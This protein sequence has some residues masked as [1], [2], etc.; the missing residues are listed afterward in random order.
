MA[1]P[2]FAFG[3]K[4]RR[5]ASLSL[6]ESPAL[7]GAEGATAPETLRHTDQAIDEKTLESGAQAPADGITFSGKKTEGAP[8]N[9]GATALPRRCDRVFAAPTQ[10]QPGIQAHSA[11]CAACRARRALRA[12]RGLRD[13]D[14]V[15]ERHSQGAPAHPGRGRAVRCLAYGPAR[16]S[17]ACRRNGG[18]SARTRRSDADRCARPGRRPTALRAAHQ[19]DGRHRRRSDDRKASRPLRP[20]RQCQPQG[21]R[22]G[23]PA[24]VHIRELHHR[25][26]G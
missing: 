24:R 15:P 1:P 14:P 4:Q 7:A 8:T 3:G 17:P 10:L 21:C 5:M 18:R 11:S 6:R 13:A 19:F 26:L 20:R 22:R 16:P 2:A 25:A 23:A 12:V 9:R